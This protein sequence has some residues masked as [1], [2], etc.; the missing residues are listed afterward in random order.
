[1]LQGCLRSDL[2]LGIEIT[3]YDD[4]QLKR[5]LACSK[6]KEKYLCDKWNQWTTKSMNQLQWLKDLKKKN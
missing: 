5:E 2:P 6:E 3:L 1:M 4:S